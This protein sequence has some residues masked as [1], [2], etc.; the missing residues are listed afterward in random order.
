[1]MQGGERWF[2]ALFDFDPHMKEYEMILLRVKAQHCQ[3]MEE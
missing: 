3:Q 2:S 1:M